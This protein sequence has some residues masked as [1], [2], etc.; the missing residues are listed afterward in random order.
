MSSSILRLHGYL[1][2]V[3]KSLHG[4]FVSISSSVFTVHACMQKPAHM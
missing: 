1:L 2:P 3:A 4:A